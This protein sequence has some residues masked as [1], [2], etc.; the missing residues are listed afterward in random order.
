LKDLGGEWE[1]EK[2]F[3]WEDPWLPSTS[4]INSPRPLCSPEP[5]LRVSDLIDEQNGRWKAEL[6]RQTFMENDANLILSLGLSH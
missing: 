1:M 6:I 5:D 3:V 2:T 4:D